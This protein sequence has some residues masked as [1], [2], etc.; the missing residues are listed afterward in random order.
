[1]GGYP[2]TSATP[3]YMSPTGSDNGGMST[4]TPLT[5]EQQ[6]RQ[7]DL[8]SRLNN[9]HLTAGTPNAEGVRGQLAA[10][11]SG[12]GT[13]TYTPERAGGAGGAGG[14]AGVGAMPVGGA[15][16]VAPGG[17]SAPVAAGSRPGVLTPQQ[18][19]Q[20]E[21][22][23]QEQAKAEREQEI[24]G[25]QQEAADY[26]RT[27]GNQSVSDINDILGDNGSVSD[28]LPKGGYKN[29]GEYMPDPFGAERG[30]IVAS[31]QG[32][33]IYDGQGN[34]HMA[35]GRT[36]PIN[37]VLH[38]EPPQYGVFRPENAIGNGNGGEFDT[39][40]HVD[41]GTGTSNGF[42]SSSTD[43]FAGQQT[44]QP[45]P[46]PGV[47][48]PD[49]APTS[50]P[51]DHGFGGSAD[52]FNGGGQSSHATAPNPAPTSGADYVQPPAPR[53]SPVDLSHTEVTQGSDAADDT[54]R[55]NTGTGFAESHDSNPTQVSQGR[56]VIDQLLGREHVDPTPVENVSGHTGAGASGSTYVSDGGP[57]T[58]G[59]VHDVTGTSAPDRN[60]YVAVD[61]DDRDNGREGG[62]D[63]GDRDEAVVNGDA[64]DGRTKN[65]HFLDDK[66]E[67]GVVNDG[68]HI[69]EVAYEG[70]PLGE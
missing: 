63:K 25:L 1:M 19:Q 10:S 47:G 8:T 40:N 5:P 11:G 62:D 32:D 69:E 14:S 36:L 53:T 65:A 42:A 58:S 3:G 37:Q 61:D 60:E 54:P 39:A 70:R 35:D 52:P 21:Q 44:T 43:P 9:T 26:M 24:K 2:S 51:A 29:Y 46:A 38:L 28:A 27:I 56:D 31:P 59:D 20:Q 6:Q 41:G 66:S 67:T 64:A 48:E 4:T 18:I 17:S 45:E 55:N 33:G 30:D 7:D 12:I 34:V 50:S 68:S 16:S 15:G 57:T 23:R 49:V 13:G 22:L